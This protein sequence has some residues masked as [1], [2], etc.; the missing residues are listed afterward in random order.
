VDK[1]VPVLRLRTESEIIDGALVMERLL[2]GVSSLF[3][4]LAL[5]LAAVGLYGTIAYSVVRRTNEIGVRMALGAGRGTILRMIL[6]ETLVVVA[7]GLLLGIP[8]AWFASRLLRAQLFELSPHDPVA[9]ASAVA[10]IVVV[11]L[12]SGF[13][14]ARRASRVDPMVALRYE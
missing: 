13:L 12:V 2:A 14:P 8:L 9:L 3:G 11:T 10:V 4:G 5:L 1:N 6:R 7:A